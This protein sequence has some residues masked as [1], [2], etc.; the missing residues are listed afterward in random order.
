[1]PVHASRVVD[2]IAQRYG[3]KIVRTKTNTRDMMEVSTHPGIKFMG[4]TLGGFIFPEFQ[5]AFDAMFATVK[6]LEMMARGGGK[7]SDAAAEVPKINLTC[8][9]ISCPPEMKGK[10]L[11]TIIE[12]RRKKRST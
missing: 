1:M 6:L 8:R 7:L 5:P 9:E 4:E 11:R 2:Q 3:L 10:I 12:A